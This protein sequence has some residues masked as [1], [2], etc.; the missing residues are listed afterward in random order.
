[1]QPENTFHKSFRSAQGSFQR[2]WIASPACLGRAKVLPGNEVHS[3]KLVREAAETWNCRNIKRRLWGLRKQTYGYQRGRA[4]KNQKSG[5][6]K[7]TLLYLEW[8]FPSSSAGKESACNAGDLGSIPGVGRFPGEG[9]GYPLQYPGLE[10]S[11]HCIVHG[12]AK[13]RTWVSHFHSLTHI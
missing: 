2:D 11:M 5:V 7:H 3:V 10:N 9:K 13:S 12:V 4:G 6:H 1:M 8:G